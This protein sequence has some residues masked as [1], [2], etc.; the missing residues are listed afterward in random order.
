MQMSAKEGNKTNESVND[1]I[2]N[3]KKEGQKVFSTRRKMLQNKIL[4]V[5][6]I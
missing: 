1:N 4:V 5:V 2:K 6:R 3:K